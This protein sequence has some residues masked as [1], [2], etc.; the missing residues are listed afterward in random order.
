MLGCSD[1][2]TVYVCVCVRVSSQCCR[3]HNKGSSP[4]ELPTPLQQMSAA[5]TRTHTHWHISSNT[6]GIHAVPPQLIEIIWAEMSVCVR[7]C[8]HFPLVYLLRKDRPFSEEGNILGATCLA[9]RALSFYFS[10]E[11]RGLPRAR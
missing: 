9:S 7:V 2:V 11:L 10:V 4:Q 6:K 1:S 8:S 3:A 5:H